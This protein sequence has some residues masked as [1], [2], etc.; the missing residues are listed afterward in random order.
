MRNLVIHLMRK[1]RSFLAVFVVVL[2]LYCTN[3]VTSAEETCDQC[4]F[5]SDDPVDCR[6]YGKIDGELVSWAKASQS[7]LDYYN[8][9]N[10]GIDP[11]SVGCDP[12]NVNTFVNSG[13]SGGVIP[14]SVLPGLGVSEG[15]FFTLQ[16]TTY[17]LKDSITIDGQTY[18]C[19]P[20]SQCYNAMK[21]YFA[22]GDGAKEMDD[23]CSTILNKIALDREIEQSDARNRIC[24]DV[25]D[26]ATS[27]PTTE[28][29]SLVDEVQSAIDAEPDKICAGF[30]FGPGTTIAPGCENATSRNPT[31]TG[32][33]SA[34]PDR[35]VATILSASMIVLG[36]LLC[37]Y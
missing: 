16:G 19:E 2:A 18:V 21:P 8:I 5:T 1:S 20:K 35:S 36:T 31:T 27:L 33:T 25:K 10:T 7:C 32:Q 15:G 24:Q 3:T 29:G 28:C 9:K 23:V 12:Q 26:S 17:V 4:F 14:N 30:A 13:L 22:D 34:S 37:Y 11:F 6:V